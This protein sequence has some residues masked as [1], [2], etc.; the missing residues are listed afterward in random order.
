MIELTLQ[1]CF[2]MWN[3]ILFSILG[4][5]LHLLEAMAMASINLSYIIYLNLNFLPHR[6]RHKRTCFYIQIWKHVS[7]HVFTVKFD[8]TVNLNWLTQQSN[9]HS[10]G[11]KHIIYIYPIITTCHNSL[12]FVHVILCQL[13]NLEM[14][15]FS[16]NR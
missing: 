4:V 6:K 2:Q 12:Y 5:L 9:F 3:P 7:F 15:E 13:H 11:C 10:N 8:L 1:F 14:E 16:I